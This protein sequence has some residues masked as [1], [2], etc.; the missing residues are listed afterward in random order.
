[1]K[2]ADSLRD[3]ARHLRAIHVDFAVIGGLAASARGEARFTR[4]IDVAVSVEADVEAE[5]VLFELRQLGYRVMATVE[6]ELV[7]RLATA[8]SIDTR[9]VVCD[10]VF[11]TCG[12]E[13]EVV[14]SA[15]DIELFPGWFCPR[16]AS[17]RCW[18]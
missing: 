15:Q 9:G 1:M 11:A 14:A 12:V 13:Q 6:Q 2:L 16:P 17:K 4:D 8:R 7:G 3:V 18:P 5:K 10:L